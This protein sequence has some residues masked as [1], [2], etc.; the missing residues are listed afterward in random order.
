MTTTT[1]PP[2]VTDRVAG[3]VAAGAARLDKH[4]PGW[5]DRID[6]DQ[7]DLSSDCRCVLGQ[8]HGDYG[9]GLA[10]LCI[11]F[12]TGASRELGFNYAV[13]DPD[14]LTAELTA[15]WRELI[16]RRRAGPDHGGS[17]AGGAAWIAV[18]I[19]AAVLLVLFG[20]WS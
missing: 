4:E 1:T 7:L 10:A 8:L 6:L 13:G 11:E 15:A 18:L 2:T 12:G 9:D 20:N 16:S 14:D 5:A 3:R 17:Q 19:V